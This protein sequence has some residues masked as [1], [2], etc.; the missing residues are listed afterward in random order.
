M[1]MKKMIACLLAILGL[2]AA[3]AQAS[4]E[5]VDVKGF[6]ELMKDSN[7]VVLD[8]RTADEFKEGHIEGAVN[9]DQAQSDFIERVKKALP[10]EKTIAIYCRSGRRSASAAERLAAEGYKAVNLKGG[11]LAWK[12]AEKPVTTDTDEV[13]D[14]RD[15]GGV[16]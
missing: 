3:C 10:T 16:D 5:N 6:V 12:E 1:K 4:Y 8:V 2:N 14:S 13:G 15:T 7:V 11:I 9:I